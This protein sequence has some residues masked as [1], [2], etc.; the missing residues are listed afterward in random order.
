[1]R[2]TVLRHHCPPVAAPRGSG[3]AKPPCRV[4]PR[5]WTGRDH[6]LDEDDQAATRIREEVDPDANI[7]VGETFDESLVGIIRVSVVAT[8]VEI[9]TSSLTASAPRHGSTDVHEAVLAELA[10]RLKAE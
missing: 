7:T 5:A 1:M 9:K 10:Q 4:S 6:T 3:V 2:P 8:G